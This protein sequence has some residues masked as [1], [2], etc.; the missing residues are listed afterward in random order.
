MAVLM[1]AVGPDVHA[2]R[3]GHGP[4]TTSSGFPAW[5]R[6]VNGV[7]L[8][9]CDVWGEMWAPVCPGLDNSRS[10]RGRVDGDMLKGIYYSARAVIEVEDGAVIE[11][12]FFVEA[13]DPGASWPAFVSNGI[14]IRIRLPQSAATDRFFSVSSPWS[15]PAN[16]RVAEGET[17]TE[18]LLSSSVIAY[19]PDFNDAMAGPISVFIGNNT[20]WCAGVGL[21]GDG[22]TRAPL[23]A[24]GPAGTDAFSVTEASIGT[25][26][27]NLFAVEG[28]L[29]APAAQS[30][31]G[32]A[33]ERATVA[34]AGALNI[35]TLI[36]STSLGDGMRITG[37]GG[38]VFD[39][40]IHMVP[41]GTGRFFANFPA[42]NLLAGPFPVMIDVTVTRQGVPV[43]T[44]AGTQA[45]I[46]DQVIVRSASYG[47]RT[48]T[49][50]VSAI[51]SVAGS[52]TTPAVLT[53]RG[54]DAEG[55]PVGN[56]N[57]TI[58][59]RSLVLTDIAV[60]PSYVS[61]TSSRGGRLTVPVAVR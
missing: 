23:A 46:T 47:I 14:L 9:M 12:V 57:A 60:P 38:T 17:R 56:V 34:E 4:L 3:G 21:L 43:P 35:G 54:S 44:L 22:T 55:N 48:R 28:R 18:L 27:T 25:A 31:G 13:I 40:P 1:L 7:Q 20:A 39:V 6:D 59:G 16:I 29:F 30:A 49:L 52:K 24:P 10:A 2:Q 51:S 53:V 11:G 5:V 19:G 50:T 42:G 15:D 61:V 26:S 58:S 8:Q 36:A 37:A 32:F 45:P 41:D 33:V